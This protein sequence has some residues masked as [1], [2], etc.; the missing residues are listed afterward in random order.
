MFLIVLEAKRS[1]FKESISGRALL[2]YHPM[3]RK[4]RECVEVCICLTQGVALLEG[5]ALL[6]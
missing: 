4:E 6:V 3:E 2:L 1:N 5:I